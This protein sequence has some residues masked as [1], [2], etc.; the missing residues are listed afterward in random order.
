MPRIAIVHTLLGQLLGGGERLVEVMG[1][2]LAKKGFEVAYVT[3][4]PKIGRTYY[5]SSSPVYSIELISTVPTILKAYV[6]PALAFIETLRCVASFKPDYIILS[7]DHAIGFLVKRLT[8]RRVLIY[9]HWPEYLFRR[10]TSLLHRIYFAVVDYLEKL[11]IRSADSILTNS[12]YT[13]K[14]LS[15]VYPRVGGRVAYPGVDTEFF[16]PHNKKA[17]TVLVVSRIT[18]VKKIEFALKVHAHLLK[19]IPDATLVVAGSLSPSDKPYLDRLI[20]MV[21]SLGTGDKVQFMLDVSE[22]TLAG[23]YGASQIFLY[24]R[25]DEHFGMVVVE[26]ISAGAVPVVPDSGGPSEIVRITGCGVALPPDVEVWAETIASLLSEPD[27][28]SAMSKAGRGT[29]ERL[30]TWENFIDVVVSSM[31]WRG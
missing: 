16:R 23:L 28:L 5:A 1:D 10:K 9:V 2:L 12:R 22:E 13:L 29:V 27:K 26:A 25:P 21:E 20:S 19:N 6:R 14:A 7:T 15:K 8:R 24:P 18:P 17:N 11:S 3:I 30:F 4:S 31:R